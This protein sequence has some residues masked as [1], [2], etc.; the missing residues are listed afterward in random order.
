LKYGEFFFEDDTFTVNKERAYAICE[1][2][3][4][5]GL[6]INWSINARPDIYDL[7]LFKEMKKLGCREFLV[8]FESGTQEI[9]NNVKKDLEIGQV[10][11]FV[12]TVKDAGIHIHGCFVLG[13]PGETKETA[14]KTIDFALGLGVDTLQFSAAVPLPGSEYFDYCKASG[15][16][17]AKSW[18]DWLEGGEQGA[19]VDYPGI[20]IEE[21]NKLVDTGLK[22]FYFRPRFMFNFLFSTRS[23][24]DLY[25]K[26]RG[27]SNF[28]NYLSQKGDK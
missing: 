28:L 10:K 8:G 23:L 22:K 18:N 20:S 26:V 17:K 4:R 11:E 9:L 12:R 21:I 5:R 7:K 6:K 3:A 24:S 16:L 15:L 19:I 1:E 25:R 27:A 14:K 2:I 13:L